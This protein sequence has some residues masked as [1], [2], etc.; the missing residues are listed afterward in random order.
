ME[1]KKKNY[2]APSMEVVEMEMQ[3]SLLAGSSVQNDSIE[4]GN[5]NGFDDG[6][7]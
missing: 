5:L 1:K 4:D 3:G 7:E 2:V 6:W